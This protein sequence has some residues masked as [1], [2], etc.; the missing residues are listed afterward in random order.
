MYAM[1]TISFAN[2]AETIPNEL[3]P[4]TSRKPR[5]NQGIGI[6]LHEA[7]VCPFCSFFNECPDHIPI[8]IATGTSKAT[9]VNL[10]ITAIS[11][12]TL[13]PASAAATTWAISCR[14]APEKMP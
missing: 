13:P 2:D 4:L 11:T 12:A 6:D 7:L 3:I 1:T 5:I 8:N 14:V 9:R 10:I